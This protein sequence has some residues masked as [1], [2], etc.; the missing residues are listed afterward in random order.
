MLIVDAIFASSRTCFN[1]VFLL[2]I[3]YSSVQTLL[4]P[5]SN[6]VSLKFIISI[7]YLVYL[8][9]S[10]NQIC[11]SPTTGD[12]YKNMRSSNGIWA[13]RQRGQ[14]DEEGSNGNGNTGTERETNS[15]SGNS[16]DTS[17]EAQWS[18]TSRKDCEDQDD[19][20]CHTS[21]TS[22]SS[23]RSTVTLTT[24]LPPTPLV[25]L[26]SLPPTPT[27]A[28]TLQSITS[29]TS[30][31]RNRPSY[32]NKSSDCSRYRVLLRWSLQHGR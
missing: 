16:Q 20:E 30:K 14:K 5:L 6:I 27:A 26:P 10:V 25:P 7:T 31:V 22:T 4:F 23:E 2:Y 28:T 21:T 29:T 13:L 19:D 15:N 24:T 17:I 18:T 32:S 9:L 8:S 12:T 1:Y 3:L 11:R